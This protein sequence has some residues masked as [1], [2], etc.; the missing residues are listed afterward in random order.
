MMKGFHEIP[1]NLKQ[2]SPQNPLKIP[3]KSPQNPLKIPKNPEIS[4]RFFFIGWWATILPQMLHTTDL[5]ME[6]SQF[7]G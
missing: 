5:G 7:F 3:S 1:S 4:P 2:K 6:G